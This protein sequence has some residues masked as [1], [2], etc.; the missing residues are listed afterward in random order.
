MT[1]P[2]Y[3]ARIVFQSGPDL[4]D[5]NAPLKISIEFESPDDLYDD[6]A[7]AHAVATHVFQTKIKAAVDEYIESIDSD[8]SV[9]HIVLGE[10][11]ELPYSEEEEEEDEEEWSPLT[12]KESTKH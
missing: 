6:D 1:A 5:I 8:A 12:E 9:E 10:G 3:T 2:K 4:T 7:P 11:E